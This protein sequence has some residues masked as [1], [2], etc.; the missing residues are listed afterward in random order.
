MNFAATLISWL[1]FFSLSWWIQWH[2]TQVLQKHVEE[3][4]QELLDRSK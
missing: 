3:L 4:K 1:L 2:H